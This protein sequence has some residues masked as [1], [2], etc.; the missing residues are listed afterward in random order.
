MTCDGTNKAAGYVGCEPPVTDNGGVYQGTKYIE[1]SCL[2]AAQ[3]FGETHYEFWTNEKRRA[4]HG[5]SSL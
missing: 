4:R 3:V 2:Q 1:V 5:S